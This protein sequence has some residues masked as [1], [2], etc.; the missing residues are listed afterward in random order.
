MGSPLVMFCALG[1]GIVLAVIACWPVR[2]LPSFLQNDNENM[3]AS[4]QK[5]ALDLRTLGAGGFSVQLQSYRETLGTFL[6]E[7]LVFKVTLAGISLLAGCYLL[8]QQWSVLPL[9]LL[10]LLVCSAALIGT[11]IFARVWKKRQFEAG[12]ADALNL[13]AGAVSTGETL[14]N[15]ISYAGQTL[16]GI[17]G[18][19]FR[20]MG[21]EMAVGQPADE[22]LMRA[23]QRFPYPQFLF[24]A[25]AVRANIS[26]GGQLNDVLKSLSRVMFN[27]RSLDKKKMAMTAEARLS[28]KIVGAIPLIFLV[29]MKVIMPLDFD[30]V[31][32]NPEGKPILYYVLGSELLGA[33]IIW[34]LMRGVD[35]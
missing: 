27:S 24:F 32:F 10:S 4:E 8:H 19:A 20:R 29:I 31:M 6:G 23:C 9:W 7:R 14:N 28:A 12:F 30:Y 34:K 11:L 5:S 1:V 35:S 16:E 13:I 33:A 17:V 3:A 26:R 18:H 2:K 25:L 21:Q 22:V 15:A